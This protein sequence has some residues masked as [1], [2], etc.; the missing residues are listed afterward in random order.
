MGLPAQFC[1]FGA[2]V[3]KSLAEHVSALPSDI[4]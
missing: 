3:L 2:S 1:I 4:R